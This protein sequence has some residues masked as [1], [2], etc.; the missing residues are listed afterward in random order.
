MWMNPT[1]LV[2][3]GSLLLAGIG[4]IL[5]YESDRLWSK[6]PIFG[7]VLWALGSFLVAPLASVCIYYVNAAATYVLNYLF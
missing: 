3:F 2:V 6:Y 1:L 5:M 4:A 7:A